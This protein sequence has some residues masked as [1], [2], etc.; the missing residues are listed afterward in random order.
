MKC[1]TIKQPWA[2]LILAGAKDVENR[3]WSTPHRG[4]LGIHVALKA[5]DKSVLQT[6]PLQYREF[7]RYLLM[8]NEMAGHVIGTVQMV[9]VIENS[10]SPWAFPGLKHWILR[11]PELTEPVAAKGRL[12]VWELDQIGQMAHVFA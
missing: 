12:Q 9:D 3:S 8:A 4:A 2:G 10:K 1:L 11:E 7:A 5:A 6:V